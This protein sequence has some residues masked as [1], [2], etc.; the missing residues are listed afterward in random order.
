[1]TTHPPRKILIVLLGAIG[2]V[3]Q[4]LTLAKRIK[5]SWPEAH[6]SWAVEPPSRAI[7]EASSAVDQVFVFDRPRGFSAYPR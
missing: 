7:V 3:A 1:M 4:G 5:D 2:D 6:L